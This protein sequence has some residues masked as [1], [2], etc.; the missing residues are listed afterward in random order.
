Q[1]DWAYTLVVSNAGLSDATGVTVVAPLPPDVQFV[2]ASSSQGLAQEEQDGRIRAG[3]GAIA[4]GKSATV[5]VI[6]LP[7]AAST[8]AGSIRL[9]ASVGG[10][11]ADPHLGN[12]QASQTI[13]VLPSVSLAVSLVSTPQTIESGQSLTFTATVTN[14]GATPATDVV[15]SLP[16]VGSLFCN[17]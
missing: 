16:P 17:S 3:L 9:S 4:A 13:P 10:N 8:A 14:T 12:N 15:L 2:S 5:T 11:E 1:L 6:V 7:T